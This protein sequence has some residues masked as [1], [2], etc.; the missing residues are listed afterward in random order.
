MTRSIPSSD[1][2]TT[3]GIRVEVF[4]GKESASRHA[5]GVLSGWVEPAPGALLAAATG[6][7]PTMTYR[8]FVERVRTPDLRLIELDE[9]GGLDMDD[10]ATCGHYLQ[11]HLVKPLG[12]SADRFTA[13]ASDAGDP[14]AECARI[15]RWLRE[16][17]PIDVCVLGLGR[18]GH[19]AMNEP[20]TA[21]DRACHVAQLADSTL[22]HPMLRLARRRP[23]HGLTLGL[24]EILASRAILLLVFGEAKAA[25]LARLLNGPI[26][27]DFPATALR[28]H[29]RTVCIADRDAA[30]RLTAAQ[31]ENCDATTS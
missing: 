7:S 18:N 24:G 4:P 27:T 29:P 19:L 23:T 6:D 11:Q 16:H 17:G 20:G 28:R 31:L 5:A 22:A 1:D 12:L 14:A 13:F 3:G 15:A 30:S 2:G 8:H 10:P 21:I 25:P 9:W 26:S